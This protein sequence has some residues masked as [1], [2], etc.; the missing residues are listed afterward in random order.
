MKRWWQICLKVIYM[1]CLYLSMYIGYIALQE[2]YVEN[3]TSRAGIIQM[4]LGL[5]ACNHVLKILQFVGEYFI[6]IVLGLT[7]FTTISVM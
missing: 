5:P 7:T 6:T 3:C 4:V 2:F 1:A